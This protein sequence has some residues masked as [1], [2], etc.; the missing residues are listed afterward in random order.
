LA[1]YNLPA[2]ADERDPLVVTFFLPRV[3]PVAD[4]DHA[5]VPVQVFPTQSADFSTPQAY[6]YHDVNDG[7]IKCWQRLDYSYKFVS[8]WSTLALTPAPDQP[9]MVEQWP[10]FAYHVWQ[11]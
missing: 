5:L 3:L 1:V 7:A 6:R 9:G 11:P 2:T 8:S 4:Q 10:R